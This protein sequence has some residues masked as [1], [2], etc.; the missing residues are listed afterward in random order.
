MKRAAGFGLPPFLLFAL[1][2]FLDRF[3]F[4]QFRTQNRYAVLLE[5][6]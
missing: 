2:P 6:L 3:V 1:A 5:L 4:T